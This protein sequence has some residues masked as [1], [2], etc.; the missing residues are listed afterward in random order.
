VSAAGVPEGA[1]THALY[2]VLAQLEEA[3]STSSSAAIAPRRW[4]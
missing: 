3:K 4:R 1:M 2:E